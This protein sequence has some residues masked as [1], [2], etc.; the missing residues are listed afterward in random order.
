MNTKLRP[1]VQDI[2][3]DTDFFSYYRLDLYGRTC[4]FWSDDEGVCGNIA[5]AV[6]TIDDED[7]IPPVWRAEELGKLAGPKARHPPGGKHAAEPSPLH[8][9][10]GSDTEES[11][12]VED[13]ECDDRDYCVPEDESAGSTGDYVSLLEN[14]ERFT[15]YA[16]AGAANV[17]KS[18]Y[19]ENCFSKESTHTEA[20]RGFVDVLKDKGLHELEK[21]DQG[22]ASLQKLDSDDECLEKRVFYR[23]ISGMH[24]SISLHLCY[25]YLNQSTGEWVYLLANS[26]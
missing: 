6:T 21:D 12:V 4:P 5:C 24:S 18:I 8:G 20:A 10:L 13:D 3:Q 16:G 23:L 17:W 26:N 2:T 1:L 19:R 7:S 15:G 9:A 25:D 11:C 22:S 14:P